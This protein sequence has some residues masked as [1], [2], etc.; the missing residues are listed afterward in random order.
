[1]KYTH[2]L[3]DVDNTLFDFDETE[4]LS[5]I[6]LF[7]AAGVEYSESNLAAYHRVNNEWWKRFEQGEATIAQLAPGRI[8]GFFEAVGVKHDVNEFSGKMLYFLSSHSILLDGAL[9]FVQKLAP[10]CELYFITNG[11]AQVQH[12]RVDCS[13]VAPY[14]KRSFISEEIGYSKPSPEFFAYVLSQ[15]EGVPKENILVIG[16]SL[17]SDIAG[18]A[19]AGLDTCWY[20][21]AGKPAGDVQPTFTVG[22]Y[23]ELAELIL[24]K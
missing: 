8:A 12:G 5:L 24:E 3:F 10:F 14:I 6:E 4:R 19:A 9:E 13:P 21:P 22:N 1:M 16:D 18:G 17:V 2:L 23:D 7:E 15:L 20:N 11:I